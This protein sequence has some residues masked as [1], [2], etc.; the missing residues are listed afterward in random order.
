MRAIEE[1]NTA[2]S[3]YGIEDAGYIGN[4]FTW[5][6][7]RTRRRLDRVVCNARWIELFTEFRVMHLNRTASDHY[8]FLCLVR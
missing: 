7:G 3:D 5:S 6:N 1:F 4:P 2:L 8:P